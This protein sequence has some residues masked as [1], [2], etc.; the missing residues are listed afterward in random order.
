MRALTIVVLVLGTIGCQQPREAGAPIM[1]VTSAAF[2]EGAPIPVEHTCDGRDARPPLSWEPPPEGTRELI[3][4]VDDPDAP[5][6]AFVHWLVA[7]L[8]PTTETLGRVLPEGAVEGRNDFGET[9][10]RGPCPPPG[11]EPHRYR[12]RI[13]AV[14]ELTGLGPG[15]TPDELRDATAD[16]LLA[17]G[18]RTG[19]YG[20]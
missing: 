6:G 8:P 9:G 2:E 16:L 15:F 13:L 11:D 19:T 14:A 5:S 7:G 1:E 3:V 17:E 4:V 10:W 12:F 20:R 18:A